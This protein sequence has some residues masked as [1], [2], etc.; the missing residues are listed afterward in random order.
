MNND[1]VVID[2]A[3]PVTITAVPN[4]LTLT[5]LTI[6]TTNNQTVTF[7]STS[8]ATVTVTTLTITSGA[9]SGLVLSTNSNLNISGAS[10]IGNN[11][12]FTI[13]TGS[14]LT[15]TGAAGAI[16]GAGTLNVT[17]TLAN[18]GSGVT[19]PVTCATNVNAGG[20]YNHKRNGG[21]VPTINWLPNSTALFSTITT[22]AP[23]GINQNYYNFTWNC[24][25]QTT[26]VTL[27][28]GTGFKVDNNFTVN[29]TS[30]NTTNA[31][32][33]TANGSVGSALILY[34]GNT[35]STFSIGNNI[36]IDNSA[37][38]STSNFL[39]LSNGTGAGAVTFNVGGDII[40]T[41][42]TSATALTNRLDVSTNTQPCT[43]NVSGALTMDCKSQLRV[44]DPGSNSGCN[45]QLNV[46]GNASIGKASK[47]VATDAS[48]LQLLWWGG[49]GSSNNTASANFG[50]SS[51]TSNVVIM[52]DAQIALVTDGSGSQTGNSALLTINGNLYFSGTGATLASGATPTYAFTG[53][54]TA[55][56][57]V[58]S[59]S[60]TLQVKKVASVGG[61]V[62]LTSSGSF[63]H[64]LNNSLAS[65][66]GATSSMSTILEGGFIANGTGTINLMGVNGS[67][68]TSTLQAAE[69]VTIN[70]A[71]ANFQGSQ[72]SGSNNTTTISAN[73]FSLSS[74]TVNFSTVSSSGTGNTVAMSLSGN[75]VLGSGTF[76]LQGNSATSI[77][78]T[79][80]VSVGGNFMLCGASVNMNPATA[81][82]LVGRIDVTGNVSF[83]TGT[84]SSSVSPTAL[85][86]GSIRF[87]GTS[88]Q[89]NLSALLTQTD[90]VDYTINP[91]STVQLQTGGSLSGNLTVNG[92]LDFPTLPTTLILSG[93]LT[94]S[95]NI[96][97]QG[98][99]HNISIA[100]AGTNSIGSF[101][102]NGSG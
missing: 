37:S 34:N 43:L 28:I 53:L 56:G 23:T 20:V 94:G 67:S 24:T 58:G 19:A 88:Q 9:S 89:L 40:T 5:S 70:G 84:L 14:T 90:F 65:F 61:N 52:D 18:S 41:V 12:I 26:T 1:V 47:T 10:T 98:A 83:S 2:P 39:V 21:V 16:S 25:S 74:G 80:V 6:G 72:G 96:D 91:G 36:L 81:N 59:T 4:S 85:R 44:L 76:N 66:G 68:N 93:S 77:T 45:A 22:T 29:A 33:V 63:C 50:S 97:L 71:T 13:A 46:L 87:V 17:G 101:V 15:V 11:A 51:V 27:G 99:T 79:S 100:G 31:S 64:Y 92:T 62:F 35:A 60:G 86:R 69:S 48:F 30:S 73:H 42:N 32:G 49:V 95:G 8:A 75:L 78:N 38:T 82:N 102:T 54:G 55:N 7:T 57:S 3:S